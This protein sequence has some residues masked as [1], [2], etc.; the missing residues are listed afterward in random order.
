VHTFK[1]INKSTATK[2]IINNNT[3]FYT[4]ISRNIS[5]LV[6][7]NLITSKI[8]PP[9]KVSSVSEMPSQG[10]VKAIRKSSKMHSTKPEHLLMNN[11]P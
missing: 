4:F 2:Y 10:N 6:K 11:G 7:L 8:H 1:K 9:P 3:I 5:S